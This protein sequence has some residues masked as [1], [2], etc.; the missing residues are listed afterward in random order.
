M[1][2]DMGDQS[3]HESIFP[4]GSLSRNWPFNKVWTVNKAGGADFTTIQAA[5]NAAGF[6]DTILVGNGDYPE[7]VTF[8]D[9]ILVLTAVSTMG[10]FTTANTAPFSA[11]INPVLVA[12]EAAID[13]SPS[14]GSQIQMRGF[15]IMPTC[16]GVA[17]AV[18]AVRCNSA[19]VL[20]LLD[21]KIQ[22]QP[23]GGAT[24]GP[25]YAVEYLGTLQTI[26]RCVI[27]VQGSG[28]GT[29]RAVFVSGGTRLRIY[30]SRFLDG[31]VAGGVVEANNASARVY[32]YGSELE[33][34]VLDT[35]SA[36]FYIDT[37][38]KVFGGTRTTPGDPTIEGVTPDGVTWY[39]TTL[40]KLRG[41]ENGISKNLIGH[42]SWL[43]PA[44]ITSNQNNYSPT[45]LSDATG[46]RLDTNA[47]R[48]ITGIATGGANRSLKL[49]NI[50]ANPIV[51]VSE[52]ASSTAANRFAF[53]LGAILLMPNA[54][55]ELQYDET[56]SRWRDEV[57][58]ARAFIARS[59][60]N[61]DIVSTAAETDVLNVTI[62]GNLLGTNRTVRIRIS[63]DRLNNTG[64]TQ[65][66]TLRVRLGATIMYNDASFAM[67]A[68]A[69]RASG[70][71]D[72]VLSA[73]N[74]TNAQVVSGLVTQ[75]PA[76]GA[77]TGLGDLASDE[78]DYATP[79][80]GEAAIDST[81]D[82][83]L[84]VTVDHAAS[85][86]SNSWRSRYYEVVYE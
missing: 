68:S 21:C 5:I 70:H 1:M 49:V 65:V 56:S 85:S 72:L 24:V 53:V 66:Y 64:A 38:S 35:T 57:S 30:Q 59:G 29:R 52:S 32:I 44:Q 18:S 73:N 71:L 26:D 15:W 62:P 31:G 69:T 75:G 79:L 86:A 61:V 83:T 28:G 33:S 54:G 37:T 78:L 77:T 2:M 41:R 81:A 51:L 25:F 40:L 3:D 7:K 12:G 6:H 34:G 17:G 8:N 19:G 74:A 67:V 48:T 23:G 58:P 84:R 39:D 14:I 27:D 55:I 82:M 13:V 16:P 4:P 45:G 9:K 50:G 46:M 63:F 43:T 11:R 76:G 36:D 47:A 20:D 60:T 80:Q 22:L 42:H 10:G